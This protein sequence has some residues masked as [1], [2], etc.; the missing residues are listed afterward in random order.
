MEDNK[1]TLKESLQRIVRR[2][3]VELMEV[4]LTSKAM[5]IGILLWLLLSLAGSIYRRADNKCEMDIP[6]GDYFKINLLCPR[7]AK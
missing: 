5:G 4:Y 7:T 6:L 2:E 1:E 3:T